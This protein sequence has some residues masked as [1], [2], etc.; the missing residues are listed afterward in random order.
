MK[1]FKIFFLIMANKKKTNDR[2]NLFY[3]RK[4]NREAFFNI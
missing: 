3:R 2:N 4:I 1:S